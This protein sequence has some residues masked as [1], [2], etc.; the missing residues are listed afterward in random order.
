MAYLDEQDRI[1]K[2]AQVTSLAN[3]IV[4][5]SNDVAGSAEVVISQATPAQDTTVR[6]GG[7]SDQEKSLNNIS[8]KSSLITKRIEVTRQI[9]YN[10]EFLTLFGDESKS[11]VNDPAIVNARQ[12]VQTA[13]L[14]LETTR[15]KI[16][17]T[18]ATIEGAGPQIAATAETRNTTQDTAQ[19][20]VANST[21]P[22][23]VEPGTSP[24][25]ANQ[26]TK[27]NTNSGPNSGAIP[28]VSDKV[29]PALESARPGITL[30]TP[31]VGVTAKRIYPEDVIKNTPIP[32]VLHQY[33]SY[34][35]G[36]SLHLLTAD[37]FNNITD[38]GEY[39]PT[40]VLIASAGRYNNTP[41]PTQFTRSPYFKEDFYFDGFDLDTVIGLNAASRSTNAIRYNFT[42]IEPYGFTLIDRIINL[43]NSPE[44]NSP[45]YLDQPYLLQIDF[46]GID[47][48]GQITGAIPNTTKRIPIRLLK[49][50]VKISARGAEYAITGTPFNH[51]AFDLTYVSTPKIIEVEANT[52]AK[53]FQSDETQGDTTD[54]TSQ[55]ESAQGGIWATS[56]GRIVGPDGQLV[57]VNTLNQSLLSIK[58]KRELGLFNSFGSALNQHQ[59][60]LQRDGKIEFPDK[61]VFNF[62]DPEI[63]NSLF[64]TGNFSTPKNAGMVIINSGS[65]SAK[66]NATKK[67]D[68]GFNTNSY[69]LDSRL[70]QINPGTYIDQVINYVIRNSAWAAKDLIIP[71]DGADEKTIRAAIEKNKNQP[72]YWWKIIPSIKLGKFDNIRKVFS[73]TITYTIQKYEVRNLKVPFGPQGTAGQAENPRPPVKSY[74]YIYSGKNNDILD[75]DITFNTTYYTAL[76]TY[77]NAQ[78]KLAQLAT[79]GESEK[80]RNTIKKNVGSNQDPN[81]IM[82]LIFKPQVSDTRT[83]TGSG[84]QT[85]E[86]VAMADLEASLLDMSQADMLHVKLKI[87]GDP[88]LIKQDDLF[89]TPK[90]NSQVIENKANAD[91]RLTP[92]GSIKMDNGEVYVNLTFRTPVDVDETTGLMQFTN[93]NIL[94]PMQTSLFSGLYR[95]LKVKNQF[96]SGQFTQELELIRLPRQD[97]LDHADNKPPTSDER[98]NQ[99]PGEK[100]IIDNNTLGPDFNTSDSAKSPTAES[101]DTAQSAQE[102][103]ADNRTDESS[104]TAEEQE[105]VETRALAAE[106]P[107]SVTT[108][109][110]SVPPGPAENTSPPIRLPDGVTQDPASGNY[111]YKGLVIPA[112]PG[113]D[114]F[115][116]AVTAVDNKQTIQITQIDNVSGNPITRTFDGNYTQAAVERSQNNVTF[117]ERELARFE[118]KVRTDPEFQNLNAEQQTNLDIARARRIAEVSAAKSGLAQAQA[119]K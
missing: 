25:P 43:C 17:D 20:D 84:A 68:L 12:Q 11:W 73:R 54:T 70:F 29:E 62:V 27:L 33:A 92:D 116:R 53:F 105:L 98:G 69:S 112:E 58:T 113:T 34:T 49:M 15:I 18:I 60:S 74:N 56:D 63:A 78:A 55:R 109:P 61:Y 67:G 51:G 104:R 44:V 88:S 3:G 91:D 83:I 14:Q 106:E 119:G 79:A 89:W 75:L 6:F 42:L 41:G 117:A 10:N 48:S 57:P 39:T 31:E 32:N 71:E 1:R 85:A 103:Q 9:N 7:P 86:Q 59:L 111:K 16:G 5:K 77:R 52:V 30:T 114:Q 99:V 108:E 40:K 100:A 76:T 118:N 90:L 21:S 46:F 81:A 96:R 19:R 2:Q 24:L 4:S 110:Q 13:T 93:E 22:A 64:V 28:N 50:D 35:Y 8:N 26:L 80:S 47:D 102:Q 38:K 97:K 95:I 66:D 65:Q 87:I 36:L 115:N 37:E 94:G 45:N 23:V 107:I 101:D 72:F 82:P